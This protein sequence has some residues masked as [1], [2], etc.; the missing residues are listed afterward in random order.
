MFALKSEGRRRGGRE[1]AKL[2]SIGPDFIAPSV[3][4]YVFQTFESYQKSGRV[5]GTTC[6]G[7]ALEHWVTWNAFVEEI[8]DYR[9]RV[10]NVN[11]NASENVILHICAMIEKY[12]DRQCPSQEQVQVRRESD[13][14]Y[15]YIHDLD[16]VFDRAS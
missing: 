3:Y 13:N 4:L 16:L 15:T 12:I 11:E 6:I 10:E 14:T 2:G 7:C 8:A 9:Y 5:H 1:S